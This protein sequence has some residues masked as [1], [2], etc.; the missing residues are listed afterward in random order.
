[1]SLSNQKTSRH[2]VWL[3]A[4]LVVVGAVAGCRTTAYDKGDGAARSLKQASAQVEAET[5]QID[6]TLDALNQLVNS[7]NTDL[8]PQYEHFSKSFD[9]LVRT[10]EEVE[11]TRVRMERKTAE[12][13]IMWDEQVTTINYGKIREQSEARRAEVTNQF[14]LVNTRYQEA[15]EVV[16]ALINYLRDIRTA[17]SLDLT[18]GGLD[19]VRDIAR[20]AN[21]NAGKVEVALGRLS[22]ELD[23]SSAHLSSVLRPSLLTTNEEPRVTVRTE[24]EKTED[25]KP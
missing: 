5:R 8:K 15:H 18:R 24:V 6:R 3:C 21:D 22:Q 19:S 17:L 25:E 13:F 11:K 1:M 23:N 2:F 4:T 12:Y 16:W 20:N 14:V 10:A 9:R 7:P